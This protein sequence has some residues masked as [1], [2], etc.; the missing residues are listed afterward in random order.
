MALSSLPAHLRDA[1]T[2]YVLNPSKGFDVAR[3][4]GNGF[5][6]FVAR[7]GPSPFLVAPWTLTEYR[8]DIIIPISFDETGAKTHLPFY[9]DTAKWMAEG[10]PPERL[11]EMIR[12]R[13]QTG[14]Y[15][16]PEKTGVS[17]MLSPVMRNFV[18]PDKNDSVMT[19]NIPH[20]MFYAPNVS[21]EDVG[22]LFG[23][24]HPFILFQGP[25]GYIIQIVGITEKAVINKEHEE[26]ITRLCEFNKAFCLPKR[27]AP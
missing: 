23:G 2:V 6:A 10:T 15:K 16:S 12:Q 13:Y 4:G 25:H 26:M 11:K 9:L 20:Y 24:E 19:T 17:Y 7:I 27:T 8:D 18:T 5:Y 21:N 14:H 1:A 22:G 3:K